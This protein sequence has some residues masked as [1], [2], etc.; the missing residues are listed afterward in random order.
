MDAERWRAEQGR[1]REAV[2]SRRGAHERSTPVVS[3][4]HAPPFVSVIVVCWNA[5]AVLPRCLKQL[6]DQDYPNYE[7]VVVDEGSQ[8][9]TLAIAQEALGSGRVKI[10]RSRVNRG[11]PHGRNLG[12]RSARGEIIAF[13]DAD[14]F[15][16]PNWLSRIVSAFETDDSVGAVAST[17]FF[18]ANPL[19]LNGA[20]GTV[21]RQ[22]WA[23]DLSMND[24]YER[25]RIASEALY[26]MGCG[27]AIRRSAAERVGPFDERML[28]YYDDV[29][30]GIRIWRA[31]YRVAVA[32][33]AW[34]DHGFGQSDQGAARGPGDSSRK[35]LL[36][37]RHR[38][39]V[40]LKH[41][42]LGD[43]RRWA[44]HEARTLRHAPWRRRALKLRA[45]GWNAA[46]LPS[47]LGT[48]R[49]LRRA[50]A[51]PKRLVDQSWGDG[52]PV[53]VP[54]IATPRPEHATNALDMAEPGSQDQLLYGWFPLERRDGR[55][56]R[57]AGVR[58]AALI[59]LERPARRLRID[60]AN[61]PVDAGGVDL[62]VRRVGSPEPLASVWSTH[63]SWQYVERSVEN[64]PLALPAGDYEVVFSAAEGWSDP[65]RE[66]RLLAFALSRM[67]FEESYEIPVGGLD[68]ASQAVEEQLVRG[69]LEA[70]HGPGGAYRWA[71]GRAGI[72]VRLAEPATSARLSYR[73]PP[74]PIG[75]VSVSARPLDREEPAWSTRIAWRPDDWCEDSFALALPAG[76]YVVA[77][78]AESTWSNPE[79][80]DPALPPENRSLGIAVSRL[81]FA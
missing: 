49:R 63:L 26:P 54:P 6:L 28:N 27:M 75:G 20:G 36:C 40:V 57:W 66:T 5:E 13:I 53:G 22:G 65:P 3:S 58:A 11:C 71:S 34:I 55:S 31:G 61:V 21:N 24:S 81:S 39:R 59:R 68:M 2:L 60:Y 35:R 1:L 73:M 4:T 16:A 30:Y 32:E 38:M 23:A 29:D 44:V 47:T 46:H 43:L 45:I 62:C 76:D 67:S 41:A 7:I 74:G 78:D 19:V 77:F 69:W 50:P 14:G 10:V 70:E 9:R 72:M 15:A 56:R 64:H 51:A 25:A 17:V 37:E 18:A 8:D 52:F 80:R 48:R 12:L 42:P 79:Q 33:D